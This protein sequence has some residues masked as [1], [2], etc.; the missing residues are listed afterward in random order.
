MRQGIKINQH[1]KET[2]GMLEDRLLQELMEMSETC[3]SGHAGRFVNVFAGVDADINIS[4]EDQIT[5]NLA[6]RIKA[7]ILEVLE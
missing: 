4:Y 3:S 2:K 7:R 1:E 5:A 6:G